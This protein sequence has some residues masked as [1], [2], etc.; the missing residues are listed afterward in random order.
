VSQ[1]PLPALD[2]VDAFSIR[3]RPLATPIALG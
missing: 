2:L 3:D 1:G